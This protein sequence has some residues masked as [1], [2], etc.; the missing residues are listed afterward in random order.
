VNSRF[1]VLVATLVHSC[2]SG[3]CL[4]GAYIL[5]QPQLYECT[6]VART[7]RTGIILG[8]DVCLGGY[9][10]RVWREG[11]ELFPGHFFECLNFG[12]L[13]LVLPPLTCVTGFKKKRSADSRGWALP[14]NTYRYFARG[15]GGEQHDDGGGHNLREKNSA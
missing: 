5:R 9:L 11:E 2:S 8:H 15:R 13:V 14:V 3:C 6:S 7:F 1:F 10:V 4:A 12:A